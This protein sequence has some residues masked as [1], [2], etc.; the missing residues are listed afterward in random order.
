MEGKKH[1]LILVF[2]VCGIVAFGQNNKTIYNA[3]ASGNMI[4]W[5]VAM[6]SVEAV[7]QKKDKDVLDLIN[8]QYGYIGW[9]LGTNKEDEAEKYLDKATANV[10]TLEQKKYN[11][12]MLYAYKAAF[13][14][15][16][17]GLANYKAP[18]IGSNSLE[19]ANKSVQLDAANPLA[20]MQLGNIYFFMPKMFGG[21][22]TVALSYYMKSLAAMES[23]KL[24]V[25]NNWNYLNLLGNIIQAYLALHKYEEA[26]KY[27]QKALRIEPNY[28]WVKNNL[29]PQALKNGKP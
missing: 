18:F 3:Y 22:E 9:C 11:L 20:Y 23:N 7:K 1:L 24:Y 21:S 26:K 2:A 29:Y 6:D 19:Y 14:G 10:K 4:R 17:I 25:T 5:K 28:G 12:S 15:Y 27:C 8:Y 13:V 16:E